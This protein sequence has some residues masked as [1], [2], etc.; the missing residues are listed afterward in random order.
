L[1]G[2]LNPQV[3]TYQASDLRDNAIGMVAGIE[4]CRAVRLAREKSSEPGH[5]KLTTE[6][7]DKARL[8]IA[9]VPTPQRG[10]VGVM[11]WRF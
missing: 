3:S 8:T 5:L 9:I 11:H 4:G 6:A 7:E 2:K 10:V 1:H